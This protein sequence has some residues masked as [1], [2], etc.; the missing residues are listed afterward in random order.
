MMPAGTCKKMFLCETLRGV[1]DRQDP[2]E[3]NAIKKK[4]LDFSIRKDNGD[5]VS[6]A[7][8]TKETCM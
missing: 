8:E 1:Y 7:Q 5:V 4:S 6:C 2:H 3:A